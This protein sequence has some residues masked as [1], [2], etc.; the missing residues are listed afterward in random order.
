MRIAIDHRTRYRF[1]EPQARLVQ[2]LR[3]TPQDGADQTV[4]HWS[5]GVDCDA[6]LRE[7]RDGFGNRVT[8]LYAVGPIQHLEVHVTGEVLTAEGHGIVGGAGEPLPPI[9]FRRASDRAAPTPPIVAFAQA[10]AGGDPIARLH[11][12]NLAVNARFAA[13]PEHHDSGRTAADLFASGGAA[14]PRDLAH[15]FIACARSVTVPARYVSGYRADGA[16][17]LPAPHAWAEAHVDGVGWIA[18]DPSRG[19]CT[20]ETYVRVAAGLDAATAAP[21]AGS[22]LGEGEEALDVELH[23]QRQG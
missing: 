14:S 12:L 3:L 20:D 7:G 11:A 19:V 5:I 22:R 2:L 15:L 17:A 9:L 4:V 1:S 21:V 13:V 10:H 23:V 18:F 16:E 6:R 8:M